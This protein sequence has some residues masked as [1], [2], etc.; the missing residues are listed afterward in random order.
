M[1]YIVEPFQICLLYE[2][3]YIFEYRIMNSCSHISH[4]N[5]SLT[6]VYGN[7][8]VV[9]RISEFAVVSTGVSTTVTIDIPKGSLSA[10]SYSG[11]RYAN[12]LTIQKSA[13]ILNRTQN[14]RLSQSSTI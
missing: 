7:L 14:M 8:S 3:L 9:G 5:S 6:L 10:F 1:T 4:N 12:I 13:L 11:Q 2:I